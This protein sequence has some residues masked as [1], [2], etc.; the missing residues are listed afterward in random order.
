MFKRNAFRLYRD[1]N[2]LMIN[3]VFRVINDNFDSSNLLLIA[4]ETMRLLVPTLKDAKF[5]KF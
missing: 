1:W 3:K 2:K 5:V 4:L